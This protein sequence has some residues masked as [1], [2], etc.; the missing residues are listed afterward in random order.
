MLLFALN[1]LI[2]KIDYY[3]YYHIG[4]FKL[5]IRKKTKPQMVSISGI[6]LS[7]PPSV[8]RGPLEALYA[9]YYEMSEL[10]ILKS[11]LSKDDCV[12]ELGTGLGLLA[13]YCAKKIGSERVYTYEANPALESIIQKTFSVNN[14]DPKLQICLCGEQEGEQTFYV[15]KSFWSSS[16]TQYRDDDIKV[17]VPVISFNQELKRINPTFLLIDIEGGE[18]DLFKYADLHNVQKIVMEIHP[19]K[20]GEEKANFVK[21]KLI[22]Q[23]FYVDQTVSSGN[24]LFFRRL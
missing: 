2:K 7:I 15:S 18:Y 8:T 24:E 17:Q 1:S 3:I 10:R 16:T 6:K 19:H 13:S 4:Q 5:K 21:D 11:H 20:I 23:G 9:G 14:V 12:M 22:E